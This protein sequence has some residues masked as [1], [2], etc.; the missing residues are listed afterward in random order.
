MQLAHKHTPTHQVTPTLHLKL[1][2]LQITLVSLTVMSQLKCTLIITNHL[3]FS[4]IG[5]DYAK[6]SV[7][8]FRSIAY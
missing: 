6:Q 2:L 5:P 3:S 8:S 7:I 1:Y 4:R